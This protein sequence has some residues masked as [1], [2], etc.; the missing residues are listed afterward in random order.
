MHLGIWYILHTHIHIHTQLINVMKWGSGCGQMQQTFYFFLIYLYHQFFLSLLPDKRVYCPA[1]SIRV[2][3]CL[4]KWTHTHI[5]FYLNQ[6]VN[7]GSFTLNV[8]ECV[9]ISFRCRRTLTALLFWECEMYVYAHSHTRGGKVTHL[10]FSGGVRVL[11][12]CSIYICTCGLVCHFLSART[13]TLHVCVFAGRT[14]N[15]REKDTVRRPLN[16]LVHLGFI[17]I[18]THT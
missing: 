15:N 3:N 18:Y 10:P 7:E 12:E 17:S 9:C 14:I 5:F 1:I 4:F 13:A 2:Q 11:S 6:T 16:C 8:S